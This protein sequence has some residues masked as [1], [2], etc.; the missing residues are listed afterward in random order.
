MGDFV[1][2]FSFSDYQRGLKGGYYEPPVNFSPY[3]PI[4]IAEYKVLENEHQKKNHNVDDCFKELYKRVGWDYYWKVYPIQNR[5]L[6]YAQ[7]SFPAYKFILPEVLADDWLAIVDWHKFQRD[8]ALHQPLTAYIVLKILTGG[9]NIRNALKING[10]PLLDHC[11]NKILEWDGTA[12]ILKCLQSTLVEDFGNANV[13]FEDNPIAREFW[14]ILFVE[15]A[16]L[17]AVFHDMGYPW[18]YINSLNSK[19]EHAGY[20]VDSPTS[21]AEKIIKV[22]GER[23]LFCPLNGYRL[24]DR[25]T[26][27]T[28]PNKL[29][30]LAAK[31]LRETH[32]LPGAIGFLYLNDVIKDFPTI[33][34]FAIRQFCVEWAA[35]AIMMHDMTKIYWG[36]NL[37]A[38]PENSHLRLNFDTDP[39]SCV[40]TLADIIEDFERPS[41]NFS[42]DGNTTAKVKYDSH[43]KYTRLEWENDATLKLSYKVTGNV[44]VKKES[45]VKEDNRKYFDMQYGYLDFSSCGVE[46]IYMNVF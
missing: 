7:M 8:H 3:M 6:N 41:V 34:N 43:C 14:K 32:G 45:F 27:S 4:N 16:Y 29:V 23:L 38:S 9:R 5:T 46:K 11:V 40:I 21:D 25:N 33:K 19:L 30:G 10:E 42:P 39:L 26:P 35:M 36:D 12:Y 44:R 18:Q 17:A 20:P 28:W 31:A 2:D 37:Y 22:F 24:L 13:L 1:M 15:A